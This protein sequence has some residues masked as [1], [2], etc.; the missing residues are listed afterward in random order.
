MS[1]AGTV[2]GTTHYG[3][4]QRLLDVRQPA[5]NLGNDLNKIVDVQTAAGR[6]RHHGDA[7]RAQA[8]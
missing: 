7:A 8:E 5:L 6:T 3:K 2:Y 1:F 4:M